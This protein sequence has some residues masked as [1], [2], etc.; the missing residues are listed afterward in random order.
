MKKTLFVFSLLCI[1]FALS[2]Q[3]P[4][5][6]AMGAATNQGSGIGSILSQLGNGIKPEAFTSSFKSS[7]WLSSL[8]SLKMD[9]VKGAGKMLGELGSGLKSESLAKGFNLKDWSSKLKSIGDMT[10]LSTQAESL[11]KNIVPSAFKKDF[12]VS[13]VLSSL[14]M[15][16]GMK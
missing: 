4:A 16:K 7:N 2:A 15:L 1:S 10:G 9:D 13:K 5:S 12:D 6:M 8:S 3:D 11:V 14:D